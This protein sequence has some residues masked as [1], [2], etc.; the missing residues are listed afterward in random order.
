MKLPEAKIELAADPDTLNAV[1]LDVEHKRIMATNGYI[2]AVLPCEVS[3]EDHSALI[4]LESIKQMRAMQKRAKSVPI[5]IRT[6]GKAVV[7]GPGE[8][9]E[10]ELTTGQFPNVDMVIPKGEAYDGP[11]TIAFNVDLLMRLAKALQSDCCKDRPPLVKLWI[12]DKQSS[13]LVKACSNSDQEN[14]G[15]LMPCRS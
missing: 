4:S 10:F 15:V 3:P 12:K 9:A 11:C 7:T 6:N 13:I 5:E 14:I 1:K 2:L 8:S